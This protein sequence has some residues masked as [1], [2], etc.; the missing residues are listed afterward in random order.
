MDHA[1]YS[2]RD[3]VTKITLFADGTAIKMAPDH[4]RILSEIGQSLE[5]LDKKDHPTYQHE[6][7]HLDL[8]NQRLKAKASHIARKERLP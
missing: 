8:D 5:T 4:K 2:N 6:E 7:R 1:H 3:A